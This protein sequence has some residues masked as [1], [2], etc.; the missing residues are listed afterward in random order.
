MKTSIT[1]I[2]F[3]VFSLVL[4]AQNDV[5]QINLPTTR[6]AAFAHGE[7]VEFTFEY[8][9]DEPGGVR[10]FPRPYTNG[11]PTPGY[12]ASG[13]PIY[14]GDG[15]GDAFFTINSGDAVVD[16]IRFS[17][18]TADQSATLREF[19]IPVEY[20]Y[21]ENGVNNFQFTAEQ[22]IASFLLGEQVNITFDYNINHSGG[23]RIFIRPFTDGALTPGY[24]ASGSPVFTGTGTQTANFTINSGKNIR[25]DHL[26]VTITNEDQSETLKTFFVPVNWYWSTVKITNFDIVQDNFAANG[27]SRTV[28]YDYETT[29]SAGVRIFPRPFTNN[30]LTLDYGA[31]GSTIF[32]GSGS[33]E[34]N[35][36]IN[37]GNQR[38][39]HIR[40][41]VTNP[42]Q[43]ETL[44]WILYPTDLFFGNVLIENLVTCPPSPARM[45]HG[46]RV[47]GSFDYTNNQGES[48]RMFFRPATGGDLTP[49]YGASGSPAYAPGS[50]SGDAFFT[51]NSGDAIVDQ[52]H[53]LTTNENQS[54]DWGVFRYNV[55]YEYGDGMVTSTND[56]SV[57]TTMSL[58]LGPNPTQDFTWLRM[59]SEE[60]TLV[61]IRLIDLQGRLMGQW[62]ALDLPAG[63]EIQQ[64]LN[65][66]SLNL[67]N[68]IYLIQV[69]GDTFQWTEKLVVQR[70]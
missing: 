67:T 26:R 45:L 39:D 22:E 36:T 2:L 53:F 65:L 5:C 15:L 10:I 59:S 63:T 62:P 64:E 14:S 66:S 31:C 11:A 20:H 19:Y 32:A 1:L 49:G 43:S 48:G 27:E 25:V 60:Q 9:V 56:L 41:Q 50:G 42:D 17:I 69:Q 70:N 35:F 16:E 4:F 34:C 51:I 23:T 54:V 68:G 28:A 37:S 61:N 29:E 30:N 38:V 18:T 55:R 57:P 8:S 24:G 12:G 47:N 44:L 7:R 3:S 58:Q 21:S 52:I 13:S 33:N 46:E 6:T 40:F